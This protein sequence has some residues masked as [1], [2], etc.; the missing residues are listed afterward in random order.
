MFR[1]GGTYAPAA[2]DGSRA[3]GRLLRIAVFLAVFVAVA[4]GGLVYDYSRTAVYR[5]TSRLAV[6]PPGVSDDA[7]RA[8]F[9]VSEAQAMRR[10]E[11]MTAVAARLKELNAGPVPEPTLLERLLQ[12]EA[13][14]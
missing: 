9:A 7:A 5:A 13:V 2:I 10:S 14:L 11:Y 4:G 6:E 12:F 3:R 8:H 1:I